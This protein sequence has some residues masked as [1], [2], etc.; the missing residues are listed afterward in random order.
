MDIH[1]FFIIKFYY[2]VHKIDS[3][4]YGYIH[5]AILVIIWDRHVQLGIVNM[6]YKYIATSMNIC[7]VNVM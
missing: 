7:S 3:Y 5:T 2:V 4:I 6:A 1:S